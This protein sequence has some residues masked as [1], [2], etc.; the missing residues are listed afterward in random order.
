MI[1]F[2]SL[3]GNWPGA[4]ARVASNAPK[5]MAEPVTLPRRVE[6]PCQA[7]PLT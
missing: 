4:E 2:N 3:T 6:R 7:H 5:V 1:C